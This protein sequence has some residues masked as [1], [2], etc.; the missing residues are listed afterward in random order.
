MIVCSMF[1]SVV[2]V[3]YFVIVVMF[4]FY[5]EG[6]VVVDM[7]MNEVLFLLLLFVLGEVRVVVFGIEELEVVEEFVVRINLKEIVFFMF[8][9]WIDE[10]G[11]VVI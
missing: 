5:E 2:L 10:D 8:D 9:F 1:K 6:V 7:E 3:I 11:N 4:Y